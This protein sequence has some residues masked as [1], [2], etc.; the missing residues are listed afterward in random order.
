M[1]INDCRLLFFLITAFILTI[2]NTVY[3]MPLQPYIDIEM[4]KMT[5]EQKKRRIIVH[6]NT[7]SSTTDTATYTAAPVATDN[8]NDNDQRNDG[9]NPTIIPPTKT[10]P[11]SSSLSSSSLENSDNFSSSSTT[12][13]DNTSSSNTTNVII[14]PVYYV[15]AE[16]RSL[17]IR[18]RQ[19]PSHSNLEFARALG[20]LRVIHRA[21]HDDDDND[22]DDDFAVD[23]DGFININSSDSNGSNTKE[24]KINFNKNV[25][26]IL[27]VNDDGDNE[28]NDNND[29]DDDVVVSKEF[30]RGWTYYVENSSPID[31]KVFMLSSFFHNDDINNENNNNTADKL[32]QIHA[33]KIYRQG[34]GDLWI[35][36]SPFYVGGMRAYLITRN[37]M[38]SVL[39]NTGYG[40][41]GIID[42]NN[43]NVKNLFDENVGFPDDAIIDTSSTIATTTVASSSTDASS[44]TRTRQLGLA[45]HLLSCSFT[46]SVYTSTFPR[47]VENKKKRHINNNSDTT[48]TTV[49]TSSIITTATN[50]NNNKTRSLT[51]DLVYPNHHH[52][53]YDINRYSNY[54]ILVI[55]TMRI[56][57]LNN[58]EREANWIR[59]DANTLLKVH[60]NNDTN[61]NVVSWK[62]RVVVTEEALLDP[63]KLYLTNTI[64]LVSQYDIHF[65]FVVSNKFFNKFVWISEHIPN[66]VNYN[67][68]VIKDFD[69]RIAGMPWRMFMDR[70]ND[71]LIAAPLRETITE[72]LIQNR[73]EKIGEVPL[74]QAKAW[75]GGLWNTAKKKKKNDDDDGSNNNDNKG[76]A[77]LSSLWQMT[78]FSNARSLELPF[79]E[80]Y[81]AMMDGKF[82]SWYFSTVLTES[83]LGQPVDCSVDLMWCAAA[84]S[85]DANRT[86]CVLVTVT[87]VHE[88][89]KSIGWKYN[90]Q[91]GVTGMS[92]ASR[93]RKQF[94]QWCNYRNYVHCFGCP[95]QRDIESIESKCNISQG[96]D[97]KDEEEP[98]RCVLNDF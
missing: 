91:Y 88:D 59:A 9:K 70:A 16:D 27:E 67:K 36:W 18:N 23:A 49:A 57:N 24:K 19:A 56:E 50:N 3:L 10:T 89:T 66:M 32:F 60:N 84:E 85:Y 4:S 98:I 81:F 83:F 5:D 75:M 64:D 72:S 63:V 93:S 62:I 38:K 17:E 82:A 76:N 80:Q 79:L 40:D 78:Q 15:K 11:S 2:F 1:M 12:T 33:S 14:L 31:W 42:Y 8:D 45:E 94:P 13:N 68:V 97:M 20:H 58:I 61:K 28:S 22:N 21:Y 6:N 92:A 29:N 55:T 46:G 90:Q 34:M 54:T 53:R 71:T 69:Q 39:D 52:H 41:N 74:V 7:N 87:S 26:L 37:G 73:F 95:N 35:S 65:D 43:I 44:T 51:I 96:E 48:G 77:K 86:S 30:L 47:A 25:V